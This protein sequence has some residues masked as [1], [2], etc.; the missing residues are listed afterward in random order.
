[1]QHLTQQSR[2]L[3]LVAFIA[4]SALLLSQF[5]QVHF[6]V[7]HVDSQTQV[8]QHSFDLHAELLLD[9]EHDHAATTQ[10]DLQ[11][12]SL[13]KQLLNALSVALLF[14]LVLLVLCIPAGNT[15]LARPERGSPSRPHFRS[16]QLRAPPAPMY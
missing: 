10:L 2:L 6:H 4:I 3:K 8:H 14:G 1:M 11:Q 15:P 9:H 16:P 7:H 13:I 5:A 12:A